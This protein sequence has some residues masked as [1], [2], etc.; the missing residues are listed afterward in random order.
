MPMAET[1]TGSILE[2]ENVTVQ[3]DTVEALKS[4]SFSSQAG[5]DAYPAGRRRKR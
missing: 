2:F 3:F 4:I 5:R 1:E